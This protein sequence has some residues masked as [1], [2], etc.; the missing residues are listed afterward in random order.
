MNEFKLKVKDI[1]EKK[2]LVTPGK[3]LHWQKCKSELKIGHQSMF[4]TPGTLVN[5][6]FQNA[7][8]QESLTHYTLWRD[9]L[10][11]RCSLMTSPLSSRASVFIDLY[12]YQPQTKNA[13]KTHIKRWGSC[14][15]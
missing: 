5:V 9:F 11:P 10:S 8:C 3:H 15:G 13:D 14:L 4:T 2:E 1:W 6:V 7:E 12:L